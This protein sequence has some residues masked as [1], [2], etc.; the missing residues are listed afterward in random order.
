MENC[1]RKRPLCEEVD[2]EEEEKEE[3]M[4]VEVDLF[5]AVVTG[6]E[7]NSGKWLTY[8]CSIL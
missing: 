6:L 7:N 3:R 5:Q 4:T 2:G 8:L 1:K